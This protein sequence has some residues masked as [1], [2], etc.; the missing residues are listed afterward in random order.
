MHASMYVCETV[1]VDACMHS[2]YAD[3]CSLTTLIGVHL[4]LV[5]SGHVDSGVCIIDKD[6]DREQSDQLSSEKSSHESHFDLPVKDSDCILL[7]AV[8]PSLGCLGVTE[9]GMRRRKKRLTKQQRRHTK[10]GKHAVVSANHATHGIATTVDASLLTYSRRRVSHGFLEPSKKRED[11]VHACGSESLL[12]SDS[13]LLLKN[14]CTVAADEMELCGSEHQ[15][16]ELIVS[17]P[18]TNVD[19]K[20]VGE[21]SDQDSSHTGTQGGSRGMMCVGAEDGHSLGQEMLE[22][23]VNALIRCSMHLS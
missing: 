3:L 4:Q 15:T 6:N 19:P 11:G 9:N 2:S 14:K 8:S 20:T 10:W 13:S 16:L 5:N 1:L 22:N 17:V 18:L 7:D 12:G 23:E 21:S